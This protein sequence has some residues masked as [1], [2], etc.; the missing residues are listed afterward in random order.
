MAVEFAM[1]DRRIPVG[2]VTLVFTD[3]EGSTKLWEDHP[4]PM[5]A[6]LARH[7]EILRSAI[8]GANGYVFKTIGDAFCAAFFTATEA[9]SAALN[10][11][12]AIANEPWPD[13]LSIKVRMAI[14]TGAV[15]SR[16]NDYFG[17]AVNRVARLV[18]VGYGGQILLSQSTCELTRDV[19][20]MG[21]N[22]RSLG[23]HR[24]K[25]LGRAETIFQLT[26]PALPIEF[27]ALKS[28]EN[29]ELLHNLPVQL[30]SF[31]GRD[32]E[33]VEVQALLEKTRLLTL[34]GTGGCGKTRL[35]I[36][37]AAEQLDRFVDGVWL[38]EFGL[39][40]DAS[41]ALPLVAMH[42]GIKEEPGKPVVQTLTEK[43]KSK[44]MLL[45]FDN[46]EHI[47]SECAVLA[48]TIIRNCPQ[49]KILASS[50]EALAIS[51]EQTYRVP[52]L[53]LPNLSETQTVRSL[54]QFAAAQLFIDRAVSVAPEFCVTDQNASSLASLCV[55]LDGIPLAIEL[56][57][58]RVRSLSVEEIN[59]KL[60]QR[61]RLLVGGPRTAVPRQ[62]TLR[63]LVDWSYQMLSDREREALEQLS[64]FVGQW[65]LDVAEKIC[66]EPI[67]DFELMDLVIALVEKSLLNF[68]ANSGG[69]YSYFET[70]RQYARDQLAKRPEVE[71]AVL[72]NHA[73]AMSEFAMTRVRRLRTVDEP[74]AL[75]EMMRAAPNISA[76]LTWAKNR[77]DCNLAATLTLAIGTSHQRRG[78]PREGA[79]VIDDFLKGEMDY[80]ELDQELHTRLLCERSSLALDLLD[81]EM[82]KPLAQEAEVSAN[83][84]NSVELIV[85]AKNL[86]GQVAMATGDFVDARIQLEEA[87][88]LSEKAKLW[89]ESARLRNNLGIVERRDPDGDKEA[90]SQH[91]RAALDLQREHHHQRGEAETLNS[92]GVLEQ[93]RGNARDAANLYL[94][95]A[96]IET[97]L[98]HPFG[99]AKTLS[100]YGEALMDLGEF[101]GALRPLAIAENIF[102]RIGS[103]YCEYTGELLER[104][105]A[106]FG[107]DASRLE[108]IRSGTRPISLREAVS[109]SLQEE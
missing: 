42:F 25:D 71:A 74:L 66:S 67:Q 105:A 39:I 109:A 9:V 22:V 89:I 80:S 40:S 108:G 3:I 102:A 13:Q 88:T 75:Q 57:A 84:L 86:R 46:C 91:Y 90:A 50:R 106:E 92:L 7:D 95:A 30:N 19:L 55:Q 45:L 103:P 37:V 82:A 35:M 2:T 96:R 33:L 97:I 26:H 61:F 18:S 104:A 51:G 59:S 11:Q 60:D 24:L 20:P 17:Q 28:L 6:C 5:N 31:I 99:V 68:D 79:A 87:L 69:T 49:V 100:N 98:E 43:L 8:A 23:E 21:A 16:D 38:F 52:S 101:K 70:I 58:A 32:R 72:G 1:P 4:K 63:A 48:D 65:T 41:D 29:P 56:A 73:K 94:D 34:T 36:Q 77:A 76:A 12:I 78:Y 44:R 14:H 27:P 83:Q 85:R 93:S 81:N 54:N 53:M 107:W 47:L 15:E 62:Q 64:V 10:A